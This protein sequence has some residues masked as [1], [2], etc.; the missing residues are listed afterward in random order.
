MVPILE[1]MNKRELEDRLVSFGVA[2]VE[3]SNKFIPNLAG[4]HFKD[5]IIRSGT[6]PA[7]NYAEAMD[8]ESIKDFVH[9]IKIVLK[10]LRETNVALKIVRDA[11]LCKD[12]KHLE[13][14]L[15]ECN[16]LI[17][18]FIASVKTTRKKL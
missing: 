2:I 17:A 5:Q 11:Q 8:A 18:I 13:D 16:E 9:K 6:A 7:L 12:L 14:D 15:R 3:L 1:P 10:E 4:V